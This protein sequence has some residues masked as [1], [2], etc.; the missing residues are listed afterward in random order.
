MKR[1]VDILIS[2]TLNITLVTQEIIATTLL[3]FLK[4]PMLPYN[5]LLIQEPIMIMVHIFLHALL[6]RISGGGI[7]HQIFSSQDQHAK[8]A[9]IGS[10]VL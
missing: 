7:L 2:A 1:F 10:T 6:L 3:A 5:I 4:I 9:P 8:K